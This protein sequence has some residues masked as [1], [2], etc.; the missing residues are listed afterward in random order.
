VECCR[1][2]LSLSR[3]SCALP[4]LVQIISALHQRFH[5]TFTPVLISSLSAALSAPSRSTLSTLAQEQREKE[6][7]ARISRQR[8]VLR[9]CCELALVGIIRDSPE[10]S[11]G[12]WVMRTLKELVS[13]LVSHYLR[14]L[15]IIIL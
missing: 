3:R 7:A 8:P 2:A 6:D 10:R 1:G 4:I 13:L 12:E 5:T 15:E 14:A 9:V 11:G